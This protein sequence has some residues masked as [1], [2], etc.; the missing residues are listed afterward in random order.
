MNERKPN[1]Y[2]E[3]AAQSKTLKASNVIGQNI[4]EVVMK[5]TGGKSERLFEE[6]KY[7]IRRILGFI[8]RHII[9]ESHS[10]IQLQHL[11]S[12]FDPVR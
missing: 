4:E 9:L 5:L 12:I 2:K 8:Y 11:T 10:R 6:G 3:N 1:K 7:R